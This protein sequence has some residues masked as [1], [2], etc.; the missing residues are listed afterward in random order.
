MLLILAV[1]YMEVEKTGYFVVVSKSRLVK[2]QCSGL[3]E[4]HLF[5]KKKKICQRFHLVHV[6]VQLHCPVEKHLW[7]LRVSAAVLLTAALTLSHLLT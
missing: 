6:H 1:I 3:K 4:L 5:K 7:L 2:Q